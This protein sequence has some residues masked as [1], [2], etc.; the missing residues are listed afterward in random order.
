MTNE[1]AVL[2]ASVVVSLSSRAINSETYPVHDEQ[3]GIG[4][5]TCVEYVGTSADAP[6]RKTGFVVS[7]ILTDRSGGPRTG[8]KWVLVEFGEGPPWRGYALTNL[9]PI[10][11]SKA[12]ADFPEAGMETMRRMLG[13][14]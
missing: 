14:E 8:E 4:Q 2:A 7:R 1:L 12:M 13:D 11:A 10:A 9:A 3:S 6:A 5:M